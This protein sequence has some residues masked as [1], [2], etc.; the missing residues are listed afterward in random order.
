MHHVT[1]I[2]AAILTKEVILSAFWVRLNGFVL[3]CAKRFSFLN[4]GLQLAQAQSAL[5]NKRTY[6]H[7]SQWYS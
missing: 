6:V 7:P 2:I 3:L 5:R 4:F 1:E